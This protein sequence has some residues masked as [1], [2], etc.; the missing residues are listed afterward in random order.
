VHLA[1]CPPFS[2][3]PELAVEQL[4][5]PAGKLKTVQLLPYGT[6]F[7]LKLAHTLEEPATVLLRFSARLKNEA[8]AE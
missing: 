5:G 4:D 6:R 8:E 1:F 3:T 7:D 2:R